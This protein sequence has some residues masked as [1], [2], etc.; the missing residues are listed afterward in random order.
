MTTC[1]LKSHIS[2]PMQSNLNRSTAEPTTHLILPLKTKPRRNP[3][4]SKQQSLIIKR[5]SEESNRDKKKP[6][7][8]LS[9]KPDVPRPSQKRTDGL[10]RFVILGAASLGLA[11]LL[12]GIDNGNK[13]LALGPEGPLVEEFWDNMRRYGLYIVTVSTGVIYTVFQPILELLK[14]P[15]TAIL[16]ITILVGSVYIVTQVLSAMVG[17]SNFSYDYG[18]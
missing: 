6:L 17:V 12:A 1:A 7:T 4:D 5:F 16:A 15:I 8:S 2:L 3:S 13:A 11:V 18:Y 14:N 10:R 9:F